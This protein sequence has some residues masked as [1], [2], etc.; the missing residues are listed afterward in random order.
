MS[1]VLTHDN[2]HAVYR[3]RI[4]S[5]NTMGAL[6]LCAMFIAL[7]AVSIYQIRDFSSDMS[8]LGAKLSTAMMSSSNSSGPE[9][10]SNSDSSGKSDSSGRSESTMKSAATARPNTGGRSGISDADAQFYENRVGQVLFS[11]VAG[12]NCRLALFNNQNGALYDAGTIHCG[13]TAIMEVHG[14][15]V[16]RVLKVSAAFRRP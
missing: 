15:G 1:M 2:R 14:I 11:P 10:R 16:D 7:I 6:M 4:A 12:D 8:G 13:Q 5:T 9:S 3:L